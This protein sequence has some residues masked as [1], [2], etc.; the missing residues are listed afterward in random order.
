[1]KQTWDPTILAVTTAAAMLAGAMAFTGGLGPDE[2]KAKALPDGRTIQLDLRIDRATGDSQ[3][4]FPVERETL[5]GLDAAAFGRSGA[6]L[7]FAWKQDPGTLRFDGVGGRKPRGSVRFEPDPAFV[8]QWEA[9][10]YAPPGDEELLLL[11]VHGVRLADAAKLR[12][13]GYTDVDAGDLLR[14]DLSPDRLEWIEAMRG[15]G[16]ARDFA[17]LVR[18]QSHGVDV[19]EARRFSAL[20]LTSMSVDDF[21]RL[22]GYGVGPEYLQGLIDARFEM[23]DVDAIARLAQ[24]GIAPAYVAGV[25]AAGLRDAGVDD[26]VRLH[27]QGIDTDYARD[28]VSAGLP[29]ASTDAVVRLH[30]HGVGSEYVNVVLQAL[31]AA[32]GTD[33]IVR[34]HDHGLSEDWIREMAAAGFR[35]ASPDELTRLHAH[36]VT[37]ELV[38]SLAEAGYRDL[39]VERVIRA[40]TNGAE[41]LGSPASTRG[42]GTGATK[43]E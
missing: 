9:L 42:H 20:G 33:A 23:D 12:E 26:I 29:E 11:T 40:A 39:T 35:D 14:L 15:V 38:S 2:W 30:A 25:R 36:G 7:H 43:V 18:L 3:L 6:P 28:V 17:D 24:H 27:S 5:E 13:L 34:L 16:A 31:S 22:R 19:D 21:L 37:P 32:R 4:S 8:S 41:A 1:M 10:G